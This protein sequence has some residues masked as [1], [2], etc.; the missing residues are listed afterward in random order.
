VGRRQ[1]PTHRTTGETSQRQFPWIHFPLTC[2]WTRRGCNVW[3]GEPLLLDVIHALHHRRTMARPP[4]SGRHHL[5]G[6]AK[7]GT[8]RGVFRV[9]ADAPWRVPTALNT[10]FDTT[11]Q[12]LFFFTE[13]AC[14]F[15]FTEPACIKRC[16]DAPWRVRPDPKH[17]ESS[18]HSC[19]FKQINSS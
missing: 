5:F 13:P 19:S 18:D 14:I 1:R 9:G 7:R 11:T 16:R 3:G 17:P 15:F 12:M 8:W 2:T 4:A 10:R 6:D